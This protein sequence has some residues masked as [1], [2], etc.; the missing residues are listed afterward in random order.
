MAWMGG[1]RLAAGPSPQVSQ[2]FP[3]IITPPAY[4]SNIFLYVGQS[5]ID[6]KSVIFLYV[7]VLS[8]QV[9]NL[10]DGDDW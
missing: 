3:A 2:S 10:R 6:R 1:G 4:V 7:I 5:P 8:A 9:R